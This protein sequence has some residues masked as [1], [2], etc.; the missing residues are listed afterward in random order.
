MRIIPGDEPVPNL[1]SPAR[2]VTL[3]EME[4]MMLRDVNDL[5]ASVRPEDLNFRARMDA[6][7][8]PVG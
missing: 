7:K 1:R 6:F 3:A 2:S 4:Q 5:H 8:G